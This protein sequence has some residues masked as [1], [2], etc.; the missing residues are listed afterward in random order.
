M[1]APAERARIE[2]AVEEEIADAFA[3]AEASPFPAAEE[4]MSDI[5]KEEGHAAICNGR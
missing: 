3:F 4:L 2:S 5:F 1:I